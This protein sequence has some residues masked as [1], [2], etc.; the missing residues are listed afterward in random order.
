MPIVHCNLIKDVFSKKEKQEL[1]TNVTDA[2]VDVKGEGIRKL[3]MVIVHEVESG[4]VGKAGDI[5]TLE[6]V[7]AAT[8]VTAAT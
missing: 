3:V 4:D 2:I 8:Q 1:I 6:K 7:R 5:V